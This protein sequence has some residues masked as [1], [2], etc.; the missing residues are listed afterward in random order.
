MFAA[1]AK[2]D[3]VEVTMP[4]FAPAQTRVAPRLNL[5]MSVSAEERWGRRQV[6]WQDPRSIE[7]PVDR[8]RKIEPLFVVKF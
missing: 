3:F 2:N 1:P 4:N 8:D 5:D 7:D 6:E